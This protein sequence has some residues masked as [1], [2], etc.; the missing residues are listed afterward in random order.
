MPIESAQPLLQR[1]ERILGIVLG[2]VFIV[3]G[4]G[5]IFVLDQFAATISGIMHLSPDAS[6]TLAAILI[7][8]EFLG[9]VALVARFMVVPVSVVF[10][11]LLAVFLWVL[12]SAVIQGKEIQCHCFGVLNIALSNRGEL[13]LDIILF[14]LFVLL[15]IVSSFKS[16]RLTA[17]KAWMLAGSAVVLLYFQYGAFAGFVNDDRSGKTVEVGAVLSHL[18][19]RNLEFT[20]YRLGNRVLFLLHFPDFNC[21]PCFDSFMMIS[22]MVHSHFGQDQAQRALAVFRPGDI[23]DPNDTSRLKQWAE[24]NEL[25]FPVLIAPDSVFQHLNLPKSSVLVLSPSERVLFSE[26]LP[27]HPEKIEFLTQLLQDRYGTSP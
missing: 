9:G 5:K 19:D 8:T 21:P 27:I 16:S 2:I 11:L 3:A 4:I 1:A 24:A 20:H 26:P 7:G 13:V 6:T 22:Q 23:A 10:C 15:G 17:R 14:N 18:Q 12:S 25:E